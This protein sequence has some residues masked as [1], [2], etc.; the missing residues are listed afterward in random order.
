MPCFIMRL[1]QVIII[2]MQ[3]QKSAILKVCSLTHIPKFMAGLAETTKSI[4][5]SKWEERV[6]SIFRH[7]T[8]SLWGVMMFSLESEKFLR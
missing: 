4:F 6:D 5:T 1:P 7:H 2:E 3:D 8:Y